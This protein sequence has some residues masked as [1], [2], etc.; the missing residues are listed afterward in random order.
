MPWLWFWTNV[1]I[2]SLTRSQPSL[3][4][5]CGLGFCTKHFSSRCNCILLA[6]PSPFS[7]WIIKKEMCIFISF[8]HKFTAEDSSKRSCLWVPTR[9]FTFTVKTDEL[10]AKMGHTLGCGKQMCLKR[11]LF[12]DF[13]YDAFYFFKT[14]LPHKIRVMFSKG[15]KSHKD[16]DT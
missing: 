11:C 4:L 5:K 16:K 7:S 3:A 1:C 14:D 12:S 15:I 2:I 8:M 10:V 6:F 13:S 9:A